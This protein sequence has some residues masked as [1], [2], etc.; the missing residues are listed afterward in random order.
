MM[1]M[2]SI[3]FRHIIS[4]NFSASSSLNN[5][6]EKK[7]LSERQRKE[8]IAGSDGPREQ[9]F[10]KNIP[11]VV[12]LSS[13]F[14]YSTR[15]ATAASVALSLTKPPSSDQ[16]GLLFFLVNPFFRVVYFTVRDFFFFYYCAFK[17]RDRIRHGL[18]QK[19]K[20]GR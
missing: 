18:I 13:A 11:S 5:N 17:T 1:S 12:R 4:R 2:I 6:H 9:S 3:I 10:F 15:E 8:T 7:T 20:K 16:V 14:P 19:K